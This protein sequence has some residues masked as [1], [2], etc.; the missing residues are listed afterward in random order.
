MENPEIITTIT[1]KN[2]IMRYMQG[3]VEQQL[4]IRI[5]VGDD[6][7]ARIFRTQIARI[8]DDSEQL[9]V[10]QPKPADWQQ[11]IDVNEALEVTCRMPNGTIRFSGQLSPLDNAADSPYC[12]LSFPAEIHKKQLRS[13]FRVSVLKY[14]SSASLSFA[15]GTILEGACRD[16]SQGG[17]LLHLPERDLGLKE[18]AEV[19]KVRIAIPEVVNIASAARIC[20]IKEIENGGT[21]VGVC[22]EN[23]DSKQSNQLR[24]ALIKLER[25]NI[26]K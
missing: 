19:D 6:D 21:Q 22:F 10:H 26:K 16:I 11:H 9:V 4:P 2:A 24:G 1:R 17:A 8:E 18:G 20:R 3:I 14:S 25:W 12:Q 7:D 15:D 23:L 13:N 5:A